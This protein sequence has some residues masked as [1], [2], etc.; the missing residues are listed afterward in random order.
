MIQIA[1]HMLIGDRAK[2]IMLVSALAFASLLMTQQSAVFCGLMRW[3]TATIR[4]TD[5]P[6][7]VVDPRVEQSNDVKPLRD[8][9]LARVRSVS[10][11][12]YAMPL[13]QSI[14]QARFADGTFK[15]ILLLGIDAATL[16]GAPPVMVEGSLDKLW[17]NNAVILDRFGLDKINYGRTKKLGV[18]D[19][20]EIN[21]HE[22]RIVGISE[23]DPS[24]FGQPYVYTTYE[25]ALSIVPKTRKNLGFILV[26]PKKGENK[27]VLARRIEEV[28]KLKAFT[29]EEFFWATI[30][31]YVKNT[32]IPISF[33]TTIVLGFIVGIAVSGQTFYMF[34]LE[35]MRYLG[36]L[37]AMGASNFLLSQMLITQA[38][39]VG[40]LGYGIGLG[41]TSLFG[42]A[43][44]S[45]RQPPFYLPYQVLLGTF[46]AVIFICVVAALIGIRRVS[47]LEAAEVFRG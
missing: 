40:V 11:V 13:Y 12:A 9:D 39:L 32:G 8:T 23:A 2:F 5:S 42:F 34:I 33:G 28:T 14:Q 27:E 19:T 18:G 35:N 43:A 17:E 24:F 31:W 7:W 10:G 22:A 16:T 26:E 38:L 4:N 29:D 46:F 36:A 37:K 47:R 41:L 25:R 1:L 45:L 20:F 44:L 30:I 21:D 6:I 3:T 15:A